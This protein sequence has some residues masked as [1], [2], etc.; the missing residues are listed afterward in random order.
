MPGTGRQFVPAQPP[1]LRV[2][3]VEGAAAGASAG[4]A[5]G[6]VGVLV[7]GG[8]GEDVSERAVGALTAGRA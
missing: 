2:W 5:V 6:A 1:P 8:G 4:V 3:L 7:T